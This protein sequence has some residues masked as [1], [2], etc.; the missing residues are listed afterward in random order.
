MVQDFFCGH[1]ENCRFIF[2]CCKGI[3]KLGNN[4]NLINNIYGNTSHD[5]GKDYLAIIS[6]SKIIRLCTP[7]DAILVC[8][9]V[10]L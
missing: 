7:K 5:Y 9:A 1:N 6:W 8:R 10:N 3:L 4:V 2:L